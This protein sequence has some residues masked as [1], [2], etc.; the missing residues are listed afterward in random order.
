[1]PARRSENTALFLMGLASHR[2]PAVFSEY[3]SATIQSRNA[4]RNAQETM[5]L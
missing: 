2:A 1:V 3:F 4:Y 5:L